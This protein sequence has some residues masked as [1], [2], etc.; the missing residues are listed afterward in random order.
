MKDAFL[1]LEDDGYLQVANPF[2]LGACQFVGMPL[3]QHGCDNVFNWWNYNVRSP[4]PHR[5]A[6][7]PA[8]PTAIERFTLTL[9]GHPVVDCP[10]L[11][12]LAA[13]RLVKDRVD[14][15]QAHR[16]QAEEPAPETR[17]A[18]PAA[19]APQHPLPLQPAAPAAAGESA[20][21]PAAVGGGARPAGGQP[22]AAGAARRGRA[23]GAGAAAAGVGGC[24]AQ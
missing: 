15:G 16:P 9:P 11:P 5:T 2:Q 21:G 6:A 4:L 14:S 8:W 18:H 13:S 20:A 23:G 7:D 12:P 22:G 10:A 1:R 3:L 24:D 19:G 17:S